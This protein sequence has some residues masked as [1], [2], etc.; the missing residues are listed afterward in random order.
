MPVVK[1]NI[2]KRNTIGPKSVLFGIREFYEKRNR[3]LVRRMCGGLG[4]ILMH[5]MLFEDFKRIMPDA[6]IHFACPP[7]YHDAVRDHPFI[8][9]LVDSTRLKENEYEKEYLISYNTTTA[10]GRTE[11]KLSPLFGPHRS[12]IW[13]EHCGVVLT[14]HE[15]HFRISEEEKSKGKELIESLR[16]REGPSVLISPIS[17]MDNKNLQEHQ[18]V[19][20]VDGLR[21]R[22]LYPFVSNNEPVYA[23]VK[24]DIPMLIERKIRNWMGII[25]QADY[26]ISMDTAAFHCAGGMKKPL[27]GLFTHTNAATYAKYYQ[28]AE[29]LQGPCPAG[30]CGCYNWGNCPKAKLAI[31]PCLTEITPESILVGVDNMLAK[32]SDKNSIK[33]E[34]C[35]NLSVLQVSG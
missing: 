21:K 24:N 29:L 31:K 1:T 30:Y 25:N 8:D 27:L 32:W 22:G 10:C 34:R 14:K 9:K 28:T 33:E 2:V 35:L 15:M 17:A 23:A 5:R 3:I 4:D 16:D 26:I 6:E 7:Y 12:D 11:M 13:A 19:A 20:L 18:L